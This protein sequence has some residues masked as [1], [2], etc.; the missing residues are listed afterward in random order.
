MCSPI[1]RKRERKRMRC[2]ELVD[3]KGEITTRYAKLDQGALQAI[4]EFNGGEH[5]RAEAKAGQRMML[6]SA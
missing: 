5:A 1:E 6:Y 2:Y 3:Q 4:K